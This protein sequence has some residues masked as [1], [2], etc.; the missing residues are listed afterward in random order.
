MAENGIAYFDEEKQ[1]WIKYGPWIHQDSSTIGTSTTEPNT[2]EGT[3][4]ISGSEYRLPDSID[5]I[6]CA[7]G[8]IVST[9]NLSC[10]V[11]KLFW[12]KQPQRL[13]TQWVSRIKNVVIGVPEDDLGYS[14][15]ITVTMVPWHHTWEGSESETKIRGIFNPRI[16]RK[17]LFS[18]TLELK[19]A[20]LPRWKP[21]TIIGGRTIEE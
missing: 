21:K 10:S 20:K 1:E 18:E 15:D 11:K 5:L 13:I 17:I 6:S 14:T 8:N 19:T 2:I 4:A 3:Y 12:R 16:K 7:F 9:S